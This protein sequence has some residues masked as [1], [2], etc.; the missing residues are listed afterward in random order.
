MK[1]SKILS[2]VGVFLVIFCSFATVETVS[3]IEN[4]KMNI[5]QS[6]GL[7]VGFEA[8]TDTHEDG[9]TFVWDFG[10]GAKSTVAST[11]HIYSSENLFTVRLKAFVGDYVTSTE[12]KI[13]VKSKY[14]KPVPV[15]TVLDSSDLFLHLSG[16][17][18]VNLET[19][20]LEYFWDFG[21]GSKATGVDVQHNY[22]RAGE[23]NLK[24]TVKDRLNRYAKTLIYFNTNYLLKP[25]AIYDVQTSTTTDSV[26]ISWKTNTRSFS[27]LM[28]GENNQYGLETEYSDIATSTHR[29][30]LKDFVY[31]TEYHYK[32]VAKSVWA[33]FGESEDGTFETAQELLPLYCNDQN[34][35]FCDDFESTVMDT[36]KWISI[37]GSLGDWIVTDGKLGRTKGLTIPLFTDF[38]WET[39]VNPAPLTSGVDPTFRYVDSQNYYFFQIRPASASRPYGHIIPHIRHNATWT[40]SEPVWNENMPV[41]NS[42]T[43]Y[44][45]KVIGSGN[46]FYFFI[47]DIYVGS[48]TDENNFFPVGRIGWRPQFYSHGVQYE[49]VK[50]NNNVDYSLLDTIAP[51][52]SDFDVT[53]T[54]TTTIIT[55][56]TNEETTDEIMYGVS[57]GFYT[58]TTIAN[59]T[60][61]STAYAH[62]VELTGLTDNTMYYYIVK[63]VD[64]NGN[65]STSSEHSFV[66]M[67]T[68]PHFVLAWG[69]SGTGDGQFYGSVYGVDID[70]QGNVY[71]LDDRRVQKFNS[72]GVFISKSIW[73]TG[74]S[75][76]TIDSQDNVYVLNSGGNNIKKFDSDL[77]QL[78]L[79]N[80]PW[81]YV[82]MPTQEWFFPWDIAIDS[83]DHLFIADRWKVIKM[84][85]DG[86]TVKEWGSQCG[87]DGSQGIE[88]IGSN[89]RGYECTVGQ[90]ASARKIGIDL[91]DNVYVIEDWFHHVQVFDNDGNYITR[92]GGSGSENGQFRTPGGGAFDSQN[93]MYVTDY[94]NNRVQ[95][96]T[97]NGTFISKWGSSYLNPGAGNGQFYA[98]NDIAIGFDGSVY[99][100][101]EGNY[102]IQKF[103]Y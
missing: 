67:P 43:W 58:T 54:N 64:L 53:T 20:T 5:D 15:I 99:V 13:D 18:S 78:S 82:M 68:V 71:V 30:V 73:G 84:D 85:T 57:S 75:G 3:A 91:Y 40:I 76:I 14:P 46:V 11:T 97:A 7:E 49:Y 63:S 98:P 23:Y 31:G 89:S 36:E 16:V 35:Y 45:Y 29:I 88:I 25:V 66:A 87:G 19:G 26:I 93:N 32:I 74:G 101:D 4:L 65:I 61:S 94:Y 95:K 2:G 72:Q 34:Y 27:K 100:T 48:W 51:I 52:I 103:A 79:W 69:S 80:L 12:R 96:L 92:W 60:V 83:H 22:A 21:D 59:T 42:G 62:A 50:I 41:I 1:I 102:R 28:Y 10:D 56:L 44:K 6:Q 90:F 8:V 55:W 9:L 17:N 47:D 24:L 33:V 77:G 81:E 39:L 70:S 37:T 38:T 86:N